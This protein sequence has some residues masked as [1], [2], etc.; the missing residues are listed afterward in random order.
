[1]RYIAIALNISLLGWF[2]YMVVDRGMPRNEE[3]FLAAIFFL[4]PSS[5]IIALV[6]NTSPS[7][8]SLV[9]LLIGAAKAKLRRVI[10]ENTPG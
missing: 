8:E 3:I 9:A 7:G 10:E 5:S 1:M 4:A 2:V 6:N